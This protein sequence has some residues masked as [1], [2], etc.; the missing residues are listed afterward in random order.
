MA[1]LGIDIGTTGVKAAAFDLG[2]TVLASAQADYPLLQPQPGWFELEPGKVVSG[3]EE[4]IQRVCGAAGKGRIRALASSAL[5]EAV[6]PVDSRGQ[7]LANTIVALDHRAVAQ[8]E[9]LR[10]QISPEEFF[11]ITGQSLHPIATVFKILWWKQERPE[12]FREARRFLCWNDMLAAVLGLEPAISPSL[13]ARTGLF[14]LQEQRWSARLLELAGLGE[15]RLARIVAAG[16]LVGQLPA[17]RARELGLAED[18][19]LVS[20]GWDQ[21]CAALG[22]GAVET[23]IVVNS[24]G[25]TDSLNATYEP[26]NT[27][28]RMLERNFTCTPA[29][30]PG[31]YC[32]NAFSFTGG[33]LLDW[34]REQL[35]AGAASRRDL[36]ADY[37]PQLLRRAL[38]SRHPPLVLA[39]FA[40]SGTPSMD[41]EALGAVVGLSLATDRADLAMGILEGVAQEIALNLEALL[42][43]G[44]PVRVL[45]AGSGGARS[46]ELLQLRADVLD[47]PLVPL[48]VQEAGCLACGMLAAASVQPSAA[49]VQR[50][51]R[52]VRTGAAVEPRRPWAEY[53][54]ARRRLYSRLHPALRELNR[55]LRALQPPGEPP[56]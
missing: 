1:V 48:Q 42:E 55:G 14:D 24:M 56:P 8:A 54:R 26:L 35:D 10:R 23:G 25:S 17:A 36:E 7:P 19:V 33:N 3:I 5:G 52:W 50:A 9:W 53:F 37:Y 16:Q 11:A 4:V 30:V 18:C 28:S 38:A 2:G 47:R 12:L 34:Y 43:A 6:L 22:S 32:T 20:G 40:G 13:A 49:V 15:E 31:L 51:R 41:P 29:A 45:Y 46:R 39:H 27:S 44:I 21:A